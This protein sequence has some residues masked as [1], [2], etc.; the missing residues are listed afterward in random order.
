MIVSSSWGAY[1][2]GMTVIRLLRLLTIFAVLLAPLTM[3]GGHAAMAMPAAA[4]AMD[5]HSGQAMTAE[6]CAGMSGQSDD[7][8]DH[9]SGPSIDC[10]MACS[11][12]PPAGTELAEHAMLVA[13]VEPPALA[14]GLIGLNPESD[15]PPPRIA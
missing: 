6:H 14:A 7:Q 4:K 5:H 10:M 8:S 1:L 2:G 9:K 15:P 12:L 11:C 3:T 13:I